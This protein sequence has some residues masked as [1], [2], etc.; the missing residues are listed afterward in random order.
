MEMSQDEG[1]P[2]MNAE[3]RSATSRKE[4]EKKRLNE[5]CSQT[6]TVPLAVCH[7]ERSASRHLL[8]GPTQARSRKIPRMVG[9]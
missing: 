2:Q 3:K 6:C 8:T 9:E 4:N 7:L 5:R 1:P